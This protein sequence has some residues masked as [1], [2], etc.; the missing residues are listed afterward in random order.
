MSHTGG[1]RLTTSTYLSG[2]SPVHRL[3]AR[4]KVILLAAYSVA[5]FAAG[6]WTGLGLAVLLLGAVLAASGLPRPSTSSPPSR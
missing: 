5:L 3:D 4:V 1:M 2:D 6:A